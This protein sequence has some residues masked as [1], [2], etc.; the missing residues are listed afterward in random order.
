MPTDSPP[1][2][3]H[4]ERILLAASS[5]E[6]LAELRESMPD[7]DTVDDMVH[8]FTRLLL[9]EQFWRFAGEP[10]IWRSHALAEASRSAW[11]IIRGRNVGQED[12][13]AGNRLIDPPP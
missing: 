7:E 12:R 10:A 3:T 5:P 11:F 6:E 2:P 1:T 13:T 8:T 9:Q 4:R